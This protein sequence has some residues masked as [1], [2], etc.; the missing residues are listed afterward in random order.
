MDGPAPDSQK[1]D[2]KPLLAALTCFGLW[3]MM[4]FLFQAI[5]REGGEPWETVA[6]RTVISVPC[7]LGA[8]AVTR[9]GRGVLAA[10]AQPRLLGLLT[11]SAVLIG[12]NWV[13]YVWA[14]A[15]HHTLAASLGYYINPLFNMVAAALIFRERVGPFGRVAIGLAT[16]GVALQAWAVG[17]PPWAALALACSFGG[18]SI[19]RKAAKVE[20]QTGLLI[21]CLILAL[22]ALAYLAVLHASGQGKFGT[23][24]AVT[25]WMALSGPWTAVPLVTFAYAV[26]RLPLTAISFIQF[27]TPTMLFIVGALQGEPLSAGRLASFAF[28]WAGAAVFA[29]GAWRGSRQPLAA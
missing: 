4:P 27:L 26:R 13:I 10:L 25:A 22:P 8:V 5:A 14:V 19:V 17:E 3:G 16:V 6:W 2:R 7:V 21:E 9:Q 18:Y 15:N 28:I 20:A 29:F 11:L 1:I 23:G 12:C 24:L